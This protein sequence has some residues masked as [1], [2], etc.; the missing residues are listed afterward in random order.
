MTFNTRPWPT[1]GRPTCKL[2]VMTC[3]ILPVLTTTAVAAPARHSGQTVHR[4]SAKGPSTGPH[5]TG[6]R[7]F[8]RMLRTAARR[9]RRADRTLVSDARGLKRC[10][11]EHPKHHK[12]CNAARRAVQRAGT[13]LARAEQSLARIARGTGKA[14]RGAG[15]SASGNPR[16]APQLTVSGQTLQWTR[17]ANINTY[18]L[19]SKVPGKTAKYSVVSGTA[20]TPPPVPGV[21]V[22]YSVRTTAN[23]SAWST[24][25][26]ITYPAATG[27]DTQAAPALTVSGQTLQWTKVANV[28]TYVLV[29]TVKGQAPQYSEVSRNSITPTA[30]PGATVYYS[31][32]TA[33]E[34]S[35]WSP[36]VKISYPSGAQPGSAEQPTGGSQGGGPFEMGLVSGSA[37]LYELPFIK[38]LGAHTARVEEWI[39]DPASQLESTI[40]AFAQS[41]VRV[42]LLASF[43]KEMPTA[44]QAQNLAGWA[45]RFGPGGTLLAGQE[46]PGR[47]RCHRHRVRQ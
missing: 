5:A 42:L 10:R 24:E 9:S 25:Q 30:V 37:A 17:V 45:S 11:T 33:V 14:G 20:L 28:T 18:V 36:E 29:G 38:Q 43:N 19:V 12:R 27:A 44:G 21:T 8:P 26:S 6:A 31:V 15:P 40:A 2:L 3:L 16:K 32:R 47:H 41:G 35:A 34:G 1:W 4:R 22:R 23:G 39:G 13:R 46:L 7:T